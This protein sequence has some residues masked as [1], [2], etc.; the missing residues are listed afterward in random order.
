ML[1][2]VLDPIVGPFAVLR[3][4]AYRG[5]LKL[6]VHYHRLLVRERVRSDLP[7]AIK[8][9]LPRHTLLR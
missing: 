8:L 4:Y 6:P 7:Q 2:L 9:F 5:A 3:L 1:L